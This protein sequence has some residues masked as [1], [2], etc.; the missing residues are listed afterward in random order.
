MDLDELLI[1][2]FGEG[3]SDKYK[4]EISPNIYLNFNCDL[5]HLVYKK[6]NAREVGG[7][8]LVKNQTAYSKKIA[9][10][11]MGGN[12]TMS[13][14]LSA[15]A[16][17][18]D[19]N[20]TA[21]FS[22]IHIDSLF[23]VFGDFKQD[24][25]Q[26]RHLKGQAT[27]NVTLTTQFNPDLT[28]IPKSLV[29]HLDVKIKNGELNNFEPLQGLDKYLDDDG[30]KH[31]RFADLKNEIHIENETILIPQM[32][33]RSNVTVIQ[34][35][36]RHHFDERIDYRVVAPLR[37]KKKINITEAGDAYETDLAGRIKVYFK[38][39]GT[40]DNYKIAFDGEAVKKKLAKDLKQ[41]VAELRDA[42]KDRDRRKKK[43]LE[44]ATD[45]YF[46]WDN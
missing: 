2:T 43:E 42:F 46:D 6:F 39:T 7:N 10:E 33:V 35:N 14:D 15:S 9:M 16:S 24:F 8:L 41:E 45:D 37:N 36:G 13:G 30:L 32:E 44:L 22:G 28:I 4:F 18:I 3:T 20:T 26:S 21:K 40:T 19:L 17:P 5:N 27:A 25:I 29:S 38:I 12:I 1:L 11:T 34:L 23:Y 31:L